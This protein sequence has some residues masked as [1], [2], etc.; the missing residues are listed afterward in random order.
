[1]AKPAITCANDFVGHLRYIESTRSKTEKL[2]RDETIVR[3]DADQI[4][5]GLYMEVVC[6]FEQF[7]EELFI[8]LLAGSLEHLSDRVIP[9]VTFRSHL[10]AREVVLGGSHYV[11]WLP[12]DHT[13]KR[14]KAFFRSGLPFTCLET[15]E[16]HEIE[17]VCYLRNAVAHKST[18]SI[19]K[20]ETKVIGDMKL[21]PR[22]RQP[23]G[24][25]RT[26]FRISP[27]QTRYENFVAELA[28]I[29]R[30][31]CSP[32]CDRKDDKEHRF[33]WGQTAPSLGHKIHLLPD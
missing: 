24:F 27:V 25:L 16:T 29:A 6:S 17:R 12:Y 10:V 18:Y 9:R 15:R 5:S 3:R 28:D 8:G 21:S 23:S 13:E 19:R 33:D 20:F 1:M 4:Y 7:I 31:L 30:K 11:D 26:R 14:A 22:D 2:L 32:M